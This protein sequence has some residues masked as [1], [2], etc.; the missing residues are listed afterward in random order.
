MKAA[1]LILASAGAWAVVQPPVKPPI[2]VENPPLSPASVTAL[3]KG[4][5][6]VAPIFEAKCFACHAAKPGKK[7]VK[8]SDPRKKID[9]TGGFPFSSSDSLEGRLTRLRDQVSD[10]SMPPWYYRLFHPSA[11]LTDADRAAIIG[12][13]DGKQPVPPAAAPAGK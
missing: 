4:Y 7:D 5:P 6:A 13:I 12:W 8:L 2:P 1:V 9:M 11:K 10:G 3:Q